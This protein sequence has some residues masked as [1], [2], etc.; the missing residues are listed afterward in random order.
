MNWRQSTGLSG[1]TASPLRIR[2]RLPTPWPTTSIAAYWHAWTPSSGSRPR[3]CAA[4]LVSAFCTCAASPD[5]S[6][7]ATES[8]PKD[9]NE[10]TTLAQ[11]EPAPFPGDLFPIRD[12][13]AWALEIERCAE[14]AAVELEHARAVYQ[15]E[16]SRQR[17]LAAAD[18]KADRMRVDVLT[19]ELAEANA[20][21]RSPAFVA[22]VA[23]SVAVAALLASTILVQATGEV[24]P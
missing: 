19:A 11:G 2:P 18:G 15:I 22:A 4:I 8:P 20:W 23:A 9:T 6:S 12:S 5:N 10:I 1:W 16:L 14:R 21:Y 17:A 7:D 24:R 3:I 13:I